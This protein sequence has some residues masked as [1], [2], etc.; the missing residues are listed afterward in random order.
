[1]EQQARPLE[2]LTAA[3]RD[4]TALPPQVQSKMGFALWRAQEGKKHPS[5]KP[6]TGFGGAGVLEVVEDHRGNAYRAIY[7]VRFDS[8]V[9]VL[10]AFQKKSKHGIATPKQEIDLVKARL[11]EAEAI[12]AKKQKDS[13]R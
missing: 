13:T 9:Y 1:M 5:V 4:F 2:F 12:H 10:H 3:Y 6:L 8:A 11:K 7:T